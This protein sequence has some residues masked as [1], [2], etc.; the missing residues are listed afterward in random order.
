MTA[1]ETT[2]RIVHIF[3]TPEELR[4]LA[5]E[6]E[7]HVKAVRL[8]ES[9]TVRKIGAANGNIEIHITYAQGE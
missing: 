5:D 7:A 6:M 8:G 1:A 2:R 3:T 9:L 4:Q